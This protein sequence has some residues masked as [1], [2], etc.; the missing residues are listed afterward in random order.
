[1]TFEYF[2]LIIYL[3]IAFYMDVRYSKLPNW[4]TISG[5][6]VGL[7]YHTITGI[8]GGLLF[9]LLGLIV[10]TLVL[11][12]MYFIKALGAGDVKL[13]AGIGAIMGME[14]SL[15]GILYSIIFAGLISLIII[16]LF[17]LGSFKKVIF[18]LYSWFMKIV[19]REPKHSLES[20]LDIKIKQYPFMYAVIPGILLT[21]YYF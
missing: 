20:F 17:K 14:F 1:M 3:V 13:F 4:L 9:S 7:A 6:V 5:V 12:L 16:I 21:L 2:L 11:L 8:I 19:K 10:S 15:Y 18:Y